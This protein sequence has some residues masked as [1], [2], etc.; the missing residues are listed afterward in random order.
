MLASPG[1]HT[2]RLDYRRI[3]DL[4]ALLAIVCD[5]ICSYRSDRF[6]V[7]TPPKDESASLFSLGDCRETMFLLY[8][9]MDV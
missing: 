9:A 6:K 7:R 4:N 5:G 2:H 3:S 1:L 8:N